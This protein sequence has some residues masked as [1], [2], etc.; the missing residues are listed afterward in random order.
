MAQFEPLLDTL[1]QLAA[2]NPALRIIIAYTRRVCFSASCIILCAF[3]SS[4]SLQDS[5]FRW[6][7]QVQCREEPMFSKL[8]DHFSLEVCAC[9]W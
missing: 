3:T 5:S 6:W 7:L 4:S 1:R 8:I 9:K 2:A